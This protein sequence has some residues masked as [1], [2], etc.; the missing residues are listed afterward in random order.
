MIQNAKR[1][2][3]K[4]G[5]SS[6]VT[7][8]KHRLR[9]AWLDS[10]AEDVA[11]LKQ[12]GKEVVVVSS[13][14]VVLGRN[15]LGLKK[16]AKLDEKQAAAA[17][18]QILL[19]QAWKKAFANQDIP[20]AQ[21][22]ITPDD[23]EDRKRHLNARQTLEILLAAGVVPVVNENDTT[24]PDELRFG[25]NDRLA[26]RVAQMLAADLL[27]LLS[28]VDGLYTGNPL[29]DKNAKRLERIR[30]ITPEIEAYAGTSGSEMGS[31]GMETKIMAAK[32][33]LQAGCSMAIASGQGMNPLAQLA[34]AACPATWF[35]AGTSPANARKRWIAATLS[36][37]GSIRV[38]EGAME[39]LKKGKSLLPAGVKSVE[40]NFVRGEVLVIHSPKGKEI[41]RGI[42]TYDSA[43]VAKILGRKSHEIEEILGYKGREELIHRDDLVLIT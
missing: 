14:A 36:P 41:A 4:I 2:I 22:L 1:I 21:I 34:D 28:D 43:E 13:G 12:Q 40:G 30:E 6:V 42:G 8:A 23:T 24:V 39:A 11:Q 5:S 31:G 17:C 19:M 26:A 25:D 9:S 27:V 3:V 29:R 38:D 15:M 32:M 33:A 10:V 7:Q 20:I 37:R 18:G 16:S 35:E